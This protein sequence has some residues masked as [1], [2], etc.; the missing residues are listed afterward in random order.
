MARPLRLEYPGALYHVTSK[1]NAGQKIFRN[2]KDRLDFLEL[3]GRVVERSSYGHS[4]YGLLWPV[5]ACKP[6]IGR[7]MLHMPSMSSM[8]CTSTPSKK[9]VITCAFTTRR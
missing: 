9:S 7:F 8:S 2:N 6:E 4:F 3:L 1:G 5:M